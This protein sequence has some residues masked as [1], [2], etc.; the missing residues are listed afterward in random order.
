[1]VYLNK[2]FSHWKGSHRPRLC[3]VVS[4]QLWYAILCRPFI[5]LFDLKEKEMIITVRKKLK[6]KWE[7]CYDDDWKRKKKRERVWS[8]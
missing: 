2:F 5:F 7:N 6:Q 8:K 4:V 3:N 1:M